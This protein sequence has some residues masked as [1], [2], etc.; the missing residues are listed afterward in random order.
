VGILD[1]RYT[2]RSDDDDDDDARRRSRKIDEV[3]S[4]TNS[5]ALTL[6][7]LDPRFLPSPTNDRN[8]KRTAVIPN[9]AIIVDPSLEKR[10]SSCLQSK[11][12]IR[13]FVI[14]NYQFL[15]SH[16]TT[17]PSLMIYVNIYIYVFNLS[18]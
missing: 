17:V 12:L 1:P 9:Y 13:R 8:S 3:R 6:S 11:L 4:L 16:S 18:K 7:V 5:F 10:H 14:S 2:L 15:I